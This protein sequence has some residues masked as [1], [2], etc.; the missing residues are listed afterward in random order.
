[1]A[2]KGRLTQFTL[3]GIND[4]DDVR[5][6]IWGN[7]FQKY[8]DLK[9]N[10][11]IR[12]VNVK[13]KSRSNEELELHGNESSFIEDLDLNSSP[14]LIRI[15]S[16][17]QNQRNLDQNH[18]L[19]AL[20]CDEYGTLYNV[21]L[22]GNICEQIIEHPQFSLF[23]CNNVTLSNSTILCSD[24]NSLQFYENEIK[25]FPTREKFTK[26]IKN[27]SEND[28]L[29][30]IECISLSN[31]LINGITD[32]NDTIITRGELDVGDDTGQIKIIAW[33][34]FT[35]ILK[36]INSGQRLFL[37]AFSVKKMGDHSIHL[38]PRDYSS[39]DKYE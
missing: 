2:P 15:L 6:V 21:S 8:F 16:F 19:Y 20:S 32:K 18:S 23:Q 34:G 30:F 3:R 25:T 4:K 24:E 11:L 13:S 31:S 38:E 27:L 10:C 12:L 29:A 9:L 36:G 35:S 26:K 28:D 22:A 14:T 5:I 1:M 39:I 37:N 17:G 7:D 33:K